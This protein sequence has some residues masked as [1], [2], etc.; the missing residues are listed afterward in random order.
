MCTFFYS[1]ISKFP[2]NLE[3]IIDEVTYRTTANNIHKIGWKAQ[4]FKY[5]DVSMLG[6]GCDVSQYPQLYD[7]N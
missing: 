3:G 5:A 6:H 2:G 1:N 7:T 4:Y